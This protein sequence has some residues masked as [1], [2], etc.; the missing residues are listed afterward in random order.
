MLAPN[1]VPKKERICLGP[2][3]LSNC[4]KGATGGT[5]ASPPLFWNHGIQASGLTREESSRMVR[6][7]GRATCSRTMFSRSVPKSSQQVRQSIPGDAAQRNELV[8][9]WGEVFCAKIIVEIV[10]NK[11][12]R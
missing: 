1:P 4:P 9:I 5:E 6:R 2:D 11:V 10:G 7:D 8:N 12:R 3:A